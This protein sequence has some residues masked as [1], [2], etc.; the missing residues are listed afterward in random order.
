MIDRACNGFKS[1]K[2]QD[3]SNKCDELQDVDEPTRRRFLQARDLDVEKASA[4]L[5]KCLSWRQSFV[6][7]GFISESEVPNEFAQNK[8]FLQGTDKK[9]RPI[10]LVFGSRHLPRKG[11]LD[12][13]KRASCFFLLFLLF[14]YSFLT[15]HGSISRFL[16]VCT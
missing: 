9:G 12:E 2:L 7:K 11:G 15:C 10:S 4:M 16:G 8:M 6:P 1:W 3:A 14:N 13:F 5:I